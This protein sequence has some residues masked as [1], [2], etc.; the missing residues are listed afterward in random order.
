MPQPGDRSDRPP[1][2]P[3]CHPGCFPA[4]TMPSDV[5][6]P[7]RPIWV[8][9]QITGSTPGSFGAEGG[10][11]SDGVHRDA[12]GRMLNSKVAYVQR[13]QRTD[14]HRVAPGLL[15]LLLHAALNEPNE[16]Q[17]AP[18]VGWLAAVAVDP[19]PTRHGRA[20]LETPS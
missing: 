2:P 8:H 12:P 15:H 20:R 4:R 14:V 13:R 9:D 19:L 7:Q 3:G 1:R 6:Y 17:P 10:N 16:S 5:A 18:S 11:P